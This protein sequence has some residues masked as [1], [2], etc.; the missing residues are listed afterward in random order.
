MDDDTRSPVLSWTRAFVLSA[1]VA[2]VSIG[3]LVYVPNLLVRWTR[4]VHAARVGLAVAAFFVS[5]SVIA[6]AVRWLQSRGVM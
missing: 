3:L 1:I 4:L 6:G 2:I 5:L